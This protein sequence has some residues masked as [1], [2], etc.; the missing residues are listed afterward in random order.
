MDNIGVKKG[1]V[2]VTITYHLAKSSE[3]Y[4]H[5]VAGDVFSTVT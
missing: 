5:K 1:K 3:T 2:S 4:S